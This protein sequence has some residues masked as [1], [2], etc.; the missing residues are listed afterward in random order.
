MYVRVNLINLCLMYN[1]HLFDQKTHTHTLILHHWDETIKK[2]QINV[3][4]KTHWHAVHVVYRYEYNA[5]TRV[6]T[7]LIALEN[8]RHLNQCSVGFASHSD[9]YMCVCVCLDFIVF[10]RLWNSQ[11]Y[12]SVRSI[13]FH[14]THVNPCLAHMF[15]FLLK[16]G[17]CSTE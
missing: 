10:A 13:V 4:Q 8:Y 9:I 14:P 2:P 12:N 15:D 7:I 6:S 1:P 16:K 11:D 17:W 5:F 3:I